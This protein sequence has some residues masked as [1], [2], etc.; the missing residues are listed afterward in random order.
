M[1][2]NRSEFP[3]TPD[4]IREDRDQTRQE[5]EQTVAD[6]TDKLDVP[7]RAEA[8]FHDTA[9]PAKRRTVEAGHDALDAVAHAEALASQ[10][11]TNA[12]PSIS[13]PLDDI[14]KQA[15]ESIRRRRV[16][17]AVLGAASA[18]VISW[19]ILRRRRV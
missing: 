9:Q 16:P 14:G 4:E 2:D 10:L 1:T 18:A 11:V 12:E 13:E 17:I 19:A 15:G 5:L 7:A 8:E 6:V 3:Q